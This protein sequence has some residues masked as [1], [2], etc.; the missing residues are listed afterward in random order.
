MAHL[1]LG[2]GNLLSNISKSSDEK[3]VDKLKKEAKLIGQE[4]THGDAVKRLNKLTDAE[5]Y[6]PEFLNALAVNCK[7]MLKL[8][9]PSQLENYP[10]A[11]LVNLATYPENI[12]TRSFNTDT[13]DFT[14]AVIINGNIPLSCFTDENAKKLEKIY[15]NDRKLKNADVELALGA[16]LAEDL[17]EEAKEFAASLEYH[18]DVCKKVSSVMSKNADKDMAPA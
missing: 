9:K 15:K 7:D 17:D 14:G 6:S 1:T 8:F 11:V 4:K 2:K 3:L 18:K 10:E 12:T 13:R 5:V 16:C